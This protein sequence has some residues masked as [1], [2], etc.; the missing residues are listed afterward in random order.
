MRT[1]IITGTFD[2]ITVGHQDL[3]LRSAELFENITVVVLNNSDKTTMFT[4]QE[5]FA[6]VKACF[7][8]SSKVSVVLWEG[9]LADFVG[10][11]DNPVI[12]RGVR[13][14]LDFEYEK[15]MH[16]INK[17]LAEVE[18]V[19]LP[20]KPDHYFISSG[21]VRELLRYKKPVSGFVPERAIEVLEIE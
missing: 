16:D 5:R 12:I 19:L 7:P 2:P 18:T 10:R 9:L 13:N 14:T 20:T 6:A 4:P 1:G 17:T 8:D 11:V 15:M 3:I 21:F